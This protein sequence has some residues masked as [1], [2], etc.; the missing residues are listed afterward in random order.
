MDTAWD[1]YLEG[2]AEILGEE[3]GNF[4]I[5]A[6]S[7]PAGPMGAV[8]HMQWFVCQMSNVNVKLDILTLYRHYPTWYNA[9]WGFHF[10]HV[11]VCSVPRM[12]QHGKEAG[13]IRRTHSRSIYQ[14]SSNLERNAYSASTRILLYK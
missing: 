7:K 10:T 12:P 13:S 4:D 14:V 5:T 1:K 2:L 11:M 6:M 3:G 8:L 9:G